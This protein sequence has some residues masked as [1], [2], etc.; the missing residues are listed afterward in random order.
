MNSVFKNKLIIT[1]TALIIASVCLY[2]F[3]PGCEYFIAGLIVIY[4]VVAIHYLQLI[5][6]SK[7]SEFIVKKRG[8]LRLVGLIL[9]G[10]LYFLWP[11]EYDQMMS[12]AL[13]IRDAHPEQKVFDGEVE[14]HMPNKTENNKTMTGID[15]NNNGIRDDVDIWINRNAR[16]KNEIRVFRQYARAM[17]K[18]FIT[19]EIKDEKSAEYIFTNLLNSQFCA[20][21]LNVNFNKVSTLYINNAKRRSCL[22]FFNI[23]G[24]ASAG[25]KPNTDNPMGALQNCSFKVEK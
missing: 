7:Y 20:N 13:K 15:S 6:N 22:D 5:K 4:V 16:T 2:F 24:A 11:S 21:E 8:Y 23:V 10:F 18:S 12:V 1:L 25:D 9:I 19:C 14:P 3:I 17:F